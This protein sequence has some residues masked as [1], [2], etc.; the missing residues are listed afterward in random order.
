MKFKIIINNKDF[1]ISGQDEIRNGKIIYTDLLIELKD[2]LVIYSEKDNENEKFPNLII[3]LLTTVEV[4]ILFKK[5][6]PESKEY[7][8]IKHKENAESL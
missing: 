4:A 3:L 7:I 8:P 2:N 5:K 6:D 1:P